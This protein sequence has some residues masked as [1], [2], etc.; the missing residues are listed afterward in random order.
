M[1]EIKEKINDIL[2]KQEFDSVSDEDKEITVI[3]D[4]IS[5]CMALK[6]FEFESRM[7]RTGKQYGY[8]YFYNNKK[9]GVHYITHVKWTHH[10]DKDWRTE[11]FY[12]DGVRHGPCVGFQNR[13]RPKFTVNY[14]NGKF[15]GEYVEYDSQGSIVKLM[16]YV[17]GVLHGR[18]ECLSPDSKTLHVAHYRNG[19]LHGKYEEIN[20]E[21][22]K[23]LISTTFSDGRE[24]VDV[25]TSIDVNT[26]VP[27]PEEY[28]P[29]CD[30][31]N[32]RF[33]K[34][35]LTD[36]TGEVEI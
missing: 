32:I 26:N 33:N 22:K 4:Y 17:D 34:N 28:P 19:L 5:F 6:L 30:S 11:I 25:E 12:V 35:T 21:T 24:M 23:V 16:N 29:E 15:D 27:V 3:P 8:G 14:K 36:I 20:R 7:Y 1:S 13:G 10:C 9:C 2:K 18:Y 31:E